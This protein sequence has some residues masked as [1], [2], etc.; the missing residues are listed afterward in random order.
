M[1]GALSALLYGFALAYLVTLGTF[2]SVHVVEFVSA[3]SKGVKYLGKA[4]LAAPTS[5][6]PLVRCSFCRASSPLAYPYT[7]STSLHFLFLRSLSHTSSHIPFALWHL[8]CYYVPPSSILLHATYPSSPLPSLPPH[9][10]SHR[11]RI[12]RPHRCRSSPSLRCLRVLPSSHPPSRLALPSRPFRRALALDSPFPH[13]LSPPTPSLVRRPTSHPP[14]TLHA[15]ASA[16]RRV[17]SRV[18]S[19]PFPPSTASLFPPL[20]SLPL[21]PPTPSHVSSAPGLR[22]RA[23]PPAAPPPLSP[24][25]RP[26]T[27]SL[28]SPPP[29]LLVRVERRLR[30]VPPPFLDRPSFSSHPSALYPACSPIHSHTSHPFCILFIPTLPPRRPFSLP[31]LL[32]THPS[33]PFAS[34]PPPSSLT[35]LLPY[36][37]NCVIDFGFTH[38]FISIARGKVL[39]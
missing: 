13:P 1:G 18:V 25:I 17:S 6:S 10:H 23:I 22:P 33:I 27:H 16:S 12:V 9:T 24:C 3:L 36:S 4:L 31:P 5:P 35:F 30:C 8:R 26:S 2:D 19:F 37:V 39:C 28:F 15:S 21:P 20:F 7:F 11:S 32:S 34:S 29:L 14:F 38:S